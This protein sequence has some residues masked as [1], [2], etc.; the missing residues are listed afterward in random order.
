MLINLLKNTK[1]PRAIVVFI[2]FSKLVR[3]LLLKIC[4]W[5]AYHI[6]ASLLL[7]NLCITALGYVLSIHFC[8][9]TKILSG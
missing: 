6:N 7:I 5:S 1:A 2:E 4:G 9:W 3:Q 8:I